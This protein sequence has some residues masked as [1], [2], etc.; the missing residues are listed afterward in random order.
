M[1]E[2]T[3]DS[4]Y[5][6]SIEQI[7]NI[8]SGLGLEVED[9][10]GSMYTLDLT[11]KNQVGMCTALASAIGELN[12][13]NHS[14]Q[15]ATQDAKQTV[16]SAREGVVTSHKT[17]SEAVA[18]LARFVTEVKAMSDTLT[19]LQPIFHEMK[20]A[21]GQI[22]NITKQTN[23]LALNATIEAVR[24]GEAGAGFSVVASEVKSLAVQTATYTGNIQQTLDKL[25]RGVGEVTKSAQE[26]AGKAAEVQHSA[27]SIQSAMETISS[28]MVEIDN[29]TGDIVAASHEIAG[30]A[31]NMVQEVQQLNAGLATSSQNIGDS[32]ERLYQLTEGN[33]SILNMALANGIRTIDSPFLEWAQGAVRAI[34]D[35][36]EHGVQSG[37][38]SMDAL[39]D[40]KYE[41]IPGSKPEQVMTRFTLFTDKYLP[42]I[43][44]PILAKHEKIVFCAAVDVRGYLPTHNTKFSQPQ[45]SDVE[46]NTAHCRNR[47]IFADRVG[48]TAGEHT[49]P[50]LLQLYR[51]DMGGGAY[52]M[53]K[54][55]SVPIYVQGRHWGG[56]RLA[57]KM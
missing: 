32:K 13:H 48:L 34:Q 4:S 55:L 50:F 33:Q 18:L 37:E 16:S 17:V 12:E 7:M 22:N 29:R 47:R 9:V 26:N 24:A 43:Q 30:R 53:M 23:M 56:F 42:A 38:I 54:D 44:E 31:N 21:I 28:Y 52:V 14:I 15:R 20:E 49:K 6:E 8:I 36:F 39:F 5:H 1:T 10:R 3:E 11:V 25:V 35:V 46:W 19:T 27:G 57:Y 45:G 41:P 51:R 2:S 40:S